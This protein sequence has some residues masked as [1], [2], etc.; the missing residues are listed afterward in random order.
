MLVS[1]RQLQQEEGRA[2]AILLSI[3]DITLRAKKGEELEQQMAELIADDRRKNEFLAM[4]A[5]ELRNPLAPICHSVEI[6]QT[7]SADQPATHRATQVIDHQV[8]NMSRLIDDLLDVARITHGTIELKR[9]PLELSNALTQ[10]VEVTR[11]Q[12]QARDQHLTVSLPR[13]PV[14]VEADQVRLEQIVG[15]LLSNA[16]KFTERGG[17]IW[18]TA[19]TALRG[20]GSDQPAEVVVRV[21]DDG[22]GIDSE[23]LPRIFDLFVQVDSSVERKQ[24]GLGIGLTLVK[25]LTEMHGGRLSVASAGP[26]KGA[27]FSVTLPAMS[28]PP[29]SLPATPAARPADSRSPRRILI[30]DDN[31]D[32][33]ESLAILLKLHGHTTQTAF[34]ADEAMENAATMKPDLILLDLGMPRINGYDVAKQIRSHD[35]GKNIRL[36]AV[37]GWGQEDD[38]RRSRE[39]GFEHHLVKPVDMKQLERLLDE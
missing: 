31:R 39:A 35:W 22:V 9:E 12:M 34:G 20:E 1:A 26:G 24:Q 5:H 25:V 3:E 33:A 28:E 27:E 17:H 4:L 38:V 21:R 30:V 7:P 37:T 29:A 6:L 11:Q 8:R 18:L 15:N 16:S 10:A 13:E 32:A 2:P 14:F 36:I 23:A 19:E